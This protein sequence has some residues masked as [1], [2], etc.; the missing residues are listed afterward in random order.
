[1]EQQKE[2]NKEPSVNIYL[3]G[4]RKYKLLPLILQHRWSNEYLTLSL[5]S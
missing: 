1:M 4:Q 2:E 5:S 3:L